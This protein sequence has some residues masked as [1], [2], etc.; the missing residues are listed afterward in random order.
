M[1]YGILDE[2]IQ[3]GHLQAAA[4]KKEM[5]QLQEI[6]HQLPTRLAQHLSESNAL[7]QGGNTEQQRNLNI[8]IPIED[9]D[10]GAPNFGYEFLDDAIWRTTFTADQLTTVA[11]G[12]DLDGIEWMTTGSSNLAN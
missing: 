5:Q 12:L 6:F 7:G 3:Q 1:A 8:G 9:T 11:D 4:R 10:R 2:L